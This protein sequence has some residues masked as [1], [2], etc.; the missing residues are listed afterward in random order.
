MYP[1]NLRLS[2]NAV[3]KAIVIDEAGG[4]DPLDIVTLVSENNRLRLFT[5]SIF[6]KGQ[7]TLSLRTNN[8]V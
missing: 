2:V 3:Y 5:N 7:F 1:F 6:S 8:E 4:V